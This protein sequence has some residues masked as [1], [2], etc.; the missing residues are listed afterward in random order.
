M[1]K[2]SVLRSNIDLLHLNL[3]HQNLEANL[4]N[5]MVDYLKLFLLTDHRVDYLNTATQ[6][7][8]LGG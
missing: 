7:K 6:E 4:N 1:K 3:P 2:S 8:G 5:Y